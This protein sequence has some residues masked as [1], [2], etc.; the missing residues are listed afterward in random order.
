MNNLYRKYTGVSKNIKKLISETKTSEEKLELF[1]KL[2]WTL[3]TG[4]ILV[5]E[6]ELKEDYKTLVEYLKTSLLENNEDETQSEIEVQT[7]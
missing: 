5:K 1:N 3:K 2:I 7:E 6:S 4:Q